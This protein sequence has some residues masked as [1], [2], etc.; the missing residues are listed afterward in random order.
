MKKIYY[1]MLVALTVCMF[2]ACDDDDEN[3][4]Q[5]NNPEPK[6][7]RGKKLRGDNQTILAFPAIYADYL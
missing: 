2:N 3:T 7:Q 5:I 6:E 1:L 4:T